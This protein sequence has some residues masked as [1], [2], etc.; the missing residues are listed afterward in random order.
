MSGSTRRM[1][2]SRR[3]SLR[4][5]YTRAGVAVENFAPDFLVDW[6]DGFWIATNFTERTQTA[7]VAPGLPL[8]TGSR[9][10]PTAGVTVWQE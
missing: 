9:E 4:G 6:R 1:A 2:A 10:V 8:L 5:V 3:I 7:P